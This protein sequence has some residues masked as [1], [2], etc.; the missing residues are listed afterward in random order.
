MQCVRFV[1][2]STENFFYQITLDIVLV[3]L[4]KQARIL[5]EKK[6][7]ILFR[8][9]DYNGFTLPEEFD[10]HHAGFNQTINEKYGECQPG[11]TNP[12]TRN[13]IINK[14]STHHRTTA[15][16]QDMHQRRSGNEKNK[17]HGYA[18]EDARKTS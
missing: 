18:L 3:R 11:K 13:N 2:M 8:G 10:L 6:R 14:E 9:R 16:Y 1:K 4:G 12:Q 15:V 5:S 7:R 17:L